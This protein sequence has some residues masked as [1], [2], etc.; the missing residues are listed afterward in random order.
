MKLRSIKTAFLALVGAVMLSQS[1][2]AQ[3]YNVGDLFIGFRSLN[4]AGVDYLIDVGSISQFT[5]VAAGQT[6]TLSLTGNG[7]GVLT[8]LNA[9]F[10]S[11]WRTALNSASGKLAVQWSVIGYDA[12]SNV[13]ASRDSSTPWNYRGL[14]NDS[15]INSIGNGL[16]SSV[17][18]FNGTTGNVDGAQVGVGGYGNYV[19]PSTTGNLAFGAFNPTTEGAANAGISFDQLNYNSG[20]GTFGNASV[21]GQFNIDSTGTISFT[22]AVPEPSTYALMVLGGFVLFWGMARRRALNA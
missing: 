19:N 8:D 3:T 21:L 20:S 11:T 5:S 2:Q 1:A 9:T 7:L 12:S 18:N 13:F 10:G 4:N 22:A 17:Y 14:D 16:A 15:I 6:I